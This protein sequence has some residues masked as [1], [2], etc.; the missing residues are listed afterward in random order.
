MQEMLQ[1]FPTVKLWV[2]Q[3]NIGAIALD[4]SLNYQRVEECY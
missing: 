4:T 1:E 3:D 2:D